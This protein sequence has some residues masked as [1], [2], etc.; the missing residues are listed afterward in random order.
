MVL[1]NVG[2][3]KKIIKKKNNKKNK[4]IKN[5]LQIESNRENDQRIGSSKAKTG[6]D[7]HRPCNSVCTFNRFKDE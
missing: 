4:N 1:R 2:N 6:Q 5:N 3:V 7:W